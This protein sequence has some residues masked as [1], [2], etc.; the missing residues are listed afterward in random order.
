[1]SIEGDTG[2][3]RI[4]YILPYVPSQ[5]RVRPYQIIRS[6][7]RMGHRITVVALS[8][9]FLLTE[10]L[11]ELE[12]ICQAVYTVP[13]S[14]FQAAAN[15]LKA[16]PTPTPLWAAYCHSP[17][18]ARLIR[19]LVTENQFDVAHVEH[20]RA[21]HFGE[22]LQSLPRILDAVDC[23]TALRRQIL[24]R[25]RGVLSRLLS[26]EEWMK[27]RSYEPRVYAQFHRIAITSLPDATALISLAP[28]G[29]PPIEVIPNGVDL[30][31]FQTTPADM[32]EADTLVFSGKMSYIANE[33]AAFF[34]LREILPLLRKQRPNVHLIIAGS[35]PSKAVRLE[36]AKVG[37]GTVTGFVDDLRPWIRRASVALCPMR[38]GVGIHNKVLEAMALERPVVASPL[39]VRAIAGAVG[40]GGVRVGEMRRSLPRSV[41]TGWKT[42]GKRRKRVAPHETMWKRTIA[43]TTWQRS[44]PTCIAQ[45]Y[46]TLG[47]P[48]ASN[49]DTTE[50]HQC[51]NRYHRTRRIAPDRCN[52]TPVLL[53][54]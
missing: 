41:R 50:R 34:V 46:T 36:A 10:S 52:A 16:L 47:I 51:D 24:D 9:N 11:R 17:V 45:R 40:A 31:Y 1:M 28:N 44:L 26:W 53:F 29:L 42:R 38:I 2:P 12:S 15:C 43:G 25:G 32:P 30:D 14:R 33:D 19:S 6:L 18:M 5:I 37:G 54:Y 48:G 7:A 13:H 21:A 35:S 27:L 8:D 39:S 20:L 23:I 3:L 4:L 49:L 22:E